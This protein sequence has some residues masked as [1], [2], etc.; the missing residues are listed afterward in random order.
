MTTPTQGSPYLRQ[1][2]KFPFDE[3]RDLARQI[4]QAYIDIALKVNARTIGVFG[5]ETQTVTGERW[6]LQGSAKEQQ[7]LRKVFT[8]TSTAQIA[9]GINFQTVNYFTNNYGQF[10]DNGGNWNGLIS[11]SSSATT[12]PGQISFYLDPTYINFRVDG[13]APT[14]E[15][16]I[17]IVQW[18]SQF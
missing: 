12:I 16:G 2:W 10:L 5:L 8:F 18:L 4:D 17:I 1:Q 11:G 6:N 7:S 13:A 9:H 15:S 14:L 3:I